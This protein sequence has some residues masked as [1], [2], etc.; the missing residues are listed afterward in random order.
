M[1][2]DGGKYIELI[3]SMGANLSA[4]VLQNDDAKTGDPATL[5]G[6]G[7]GNSPPDVPLRGGD[8][9]GMESRVAV[10]EAHMEH[11]RSDLAK[12]SGVPA[13]LAALKEKVEH[14][15]T[16]DDLH[17][18]SGS[19]TAKLVGLLVAIAALIAFADKIQ[20]LVS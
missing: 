17:K 4:G 14:L 13:D 11:V 15:P 6:G 16:K 18:L 7:S 8:G 5:S 20:A 19:F 9:G 2:G 1:K 3:R 12:L 10:L